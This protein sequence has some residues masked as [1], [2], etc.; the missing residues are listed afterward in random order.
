MNAGGL[1]AE[2]ICDMDHQIVSLVDMNLGARPLSIDANYW[3][4]KTI[5]TRPYP[6]DLPV[7]LDFAGRGDSKTCQSKR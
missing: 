2:L 1:I 3:S 7:I 4:G 6:G 5:R